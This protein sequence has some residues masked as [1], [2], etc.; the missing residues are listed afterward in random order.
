[1]IQPRD[2]QGYYEQFLKGDNKK[3]WDQITENEKLIE[4]DKQSI[5][6]V[7]NNDELRNRIIKNVG[8]LED[9]YNELA[10][11]EKTELDNKIDFELKEYRQ[12]AEYI[13][14]RENSIKFREAENE[15]LKKQ[16]K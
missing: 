9:Q 16:I 11:R 10:D 4:Q 6:T 1:L 14:G 3:I 15:F 7:F 5:K 13:Q 12:D 2:I 8:I